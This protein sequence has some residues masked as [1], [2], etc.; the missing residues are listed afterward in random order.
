MAIV[1]GS[2][3]AA[4]ATS[5]AAVRATT[6]GESP[7]PVVVSTPSPATPAQPTGAA[8]FGSSTG[9]GSAAASDGVAADASPDASGAA[10]V[11]APSPA[12]AASPSIG[13]STGFVSPSLPTAGIAMIG[14]EDSAGTSKAGVF[15]LA[16][17]RWAPG[18][19]GSRSLSS[20]VGEKSSDITVQL[21]VPNAATAISALLQDELRQD[22]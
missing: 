20:V 22:G 21:A 14:G 13:A 8:L 16:A 5:S 11:P 3:L 12:F 6:R 10:E 1:S 9:P 15:G 17:G 18:I 2:G 7:P 19:A 4:R